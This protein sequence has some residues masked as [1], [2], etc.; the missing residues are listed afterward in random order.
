MEIWDEIARLGSSRIT[1]LRTQ[2]IV[3]TLALLFCLSLLGIFLYYRKK[4]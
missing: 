3:T 2:A 1:S 4:A